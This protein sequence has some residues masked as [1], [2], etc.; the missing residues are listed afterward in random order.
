MYAY[1]QAN[2]LPDAISGVFLVHIQVPHEANIRP[3]FPRY[4]DVP[5]KFFDFSHKEPTSLF[6]LP[7]VHDHFRSSFEVAR[8]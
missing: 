4:L 7:Y 1:S 8:T 2:Y 6:S 5:S 3:F